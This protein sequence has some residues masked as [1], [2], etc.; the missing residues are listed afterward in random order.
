MTVR[1]P[2]PINQPFDDES[3][4]EHI[5]FWMLIRGISHGFDGT[6]D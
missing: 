2:T 4:A 6:H 3:M 1:I 5:L